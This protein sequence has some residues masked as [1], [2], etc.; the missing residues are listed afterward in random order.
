[1][2]KDGG[3]YTEE[4][5]RHAT[6]SPY[7]RLEDEASAEEV[8]FWHLSSSL[9]SSSFLLI[10]DVACI[11]VLL[12]WFTSGINSLVRNGHNASTIYVQSR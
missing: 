1:M 6:S 4:N 2:D 11:K 5:K 8:E 3:E 12:D 9:F 7:S 10:F